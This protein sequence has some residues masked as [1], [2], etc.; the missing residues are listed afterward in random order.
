METR[1]PLSSSASSEALDLW[2]HSS[3]YNYFIYEGEGPETGGKVLF[4]ARLFIGVTLACVMLICGFGN[5]IFILTL[6]MKKKLRSVTNI[7]IANLAVSDLLVAVVCCPFEMDYY[8][9]REQS[10]TFG[11]VICSSV[12]YLRMV[13]LYVSTNALLAIAVD[14]YLVIIHPLQPRVTLRTACGVLLTIWLT[15]IFVAAPTAYFATETDFDAPREPGGKVFCGQIW[16]ADRA[17]LYKS[18]SLFLLAV[19]FLAPVIIMSLCYI[20]ICH[21]LWFKNLPGVQT[22]QLR[23]RLQSRRKTVLVLVAVLLAYVFCW[24]PFYGYAIVRD[25]YPGLLLKER[26]AIALYYIVECIAISNSI[27]NTLFF[28][29]VKNWPWFCLK[30]KC[31]RYIIFQGCT[32]AVQPTAV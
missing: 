11:H 26:H 19:E 18:Y 4:M 32:T 25:F 2:N 17:L 9:V 3:E 13:S 24:S 21:E 10:W 15:S 31:E 1:R 29:T 14:R 6:A 23:E 27:I 5:L 22:K 20:R 30:G 28:V 12:S 16:P 7:L 8:V